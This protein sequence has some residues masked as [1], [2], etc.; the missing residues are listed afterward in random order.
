MDI[1]VPLAWFTLLLSAA[2]LL[3]LLLFFFF[4][5][6]DDDD[7]DVTNGCRRYGFLD[8]RCTAIDFSAI[9]QDATPANPDY[10]AC[11]DACLRRGATISEAD[12]TECVLEY[13][14]SSLGGPDRSDIHFPGCSDCHWYF[15]TA[16]GCSLYTLT[17]YCDRWASV[18]ESSFE[19][20]QDACHTNILQER[21]Y[22]PV[23]FCNANVCDDS[24][25]L[26]GLAES[27]GA[28]YSK[29]S[30][31]V[32]PCYSAYCKTLEDVQE[33][34]LACDLDWQTCDWE[35]W[36][37]H[38]SQACNDQCDT[39][40]WAACFNPSA[41]VYCDTRN[42]CNIGMGPAFGTTISSDRAYQIQFDVGTTTAAKAYL[43]Y[44]PKY[45]GVTEYPGYSRGVSES[46]WRTM[47]ILNSAVQTSGA[48]SVNPRVAEQGIHSFWCFLDMGTDPLTGYV[49]YMIVPY[50]HTNCAL[51]FNRDQALSTGHASCV[52]KPIAL[53]SSKR[54]LM[55]WRS[56][57]VKNLDPNFFFF[58]VSKDTL[59]NSGYYIM[60]ANN[61]E[62]ATL[63]QVNETT[64]DMYFGPPAFRANDVAQQTP[65]NALMVAS[66]STMPFPK[67][68]NTLMTTAKIGYMMSEEFMIGQVQ[69]NEYWLWNVRSDVS[70]YKNMVPAISFVSGTASNSLRFIQEETNNQNRVSKR[71]NSVGFKNG[72]PSEVI[73]IQNNNFL[74][75]LT[76]PVQPSNEYADGAG[77]YNRY[78]TYG[79][80]YCVDCR[81]K[82]F[83]KNTI[84]TDDKNPFILIPFPFYRLFNFVGYTVDTP[85]SGTNLVIGQT[86]TLVF[87]YDDDEDDANG[88]SWRNSAGKHLFPSLRD[89]TTLY[90]SDAV[91]AA[92]WSCA[93]QYKWDPIPP[94]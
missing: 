58:I 28:F 30:E 88:L 3:G 6:Q 31:L 94:P 87:N 21:C 7:D 75:Y 14:C 41:Q 69:D 47:L 54:T 86:D 34:C 33:E 65:A 20:C 56:A 73:P 22:D 43:V 45:P 19:R 1:G 80:N 32:H 61:I 52:V 90:K 9:C 70:W 18:Y 59:S 91:F 78:I 49:Q 10:I 71:L 50:D 67:I 83:S 39:G 5:R 79:E 25:C 63:L 23:A 60:P 62:P 4:R 84:G 68:N 66:V 12:R 36:C 53:N 48:S 57:P 8:S 92:L 2:I 24:Q 29:T 26:D 82:V 55:N 72:S 15:S 42:N 74:I 76:Q 11:Q 27:S 64:A 37:L 85:D 38:N 93:A 89:P 81:I 35:V 17:S 40:T 77:A 44:Q 13:T 51:Y 46:V 16:E